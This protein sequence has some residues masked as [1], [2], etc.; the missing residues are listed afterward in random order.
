MPGSE[1]YRPVD[2]HNVV[3]D[4]RILSM[5]IDES[6]YFANAAY[7]EATVFAQVAL[8]EDLAHVILMCP[9]V[10]AIDLSALGALE[11][12]NTR[13]KEND[14]VLHLSEV[15]SPVMDALERSDFLNH[16]SGEIFLYH[17]RAIMALS[18][19]ETADPAVT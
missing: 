13:L 18:T 4:P 15:K 19:R 11:E 16:L 1:H 6:L 9:A 10:N 17:H 2:R 3:T 5:R 12:I 14:V 7:L 8:R